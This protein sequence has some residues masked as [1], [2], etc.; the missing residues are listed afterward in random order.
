[1]TGTPLSSP[2]HHLPRRGLTRADILSRL[3]FLL[4]MLV[5]TTAL[6][7]S[8]WLAGQLGGLL[9]RWTWP[10]STPGDAPG[11]AFRLV[12]HLGSP[13]AAW[14][15]EARADLPPGWLFWLLTLLLFGGSQ[16]GLAVPLFTIARRIARRR[17]FASRGDLERRLTADAVLAKVDVIRPGL[18][19]VDS[20]DEA[21]RAKKEERRTD[22]LEVGR[23]LGTDVL[24]GTPLYLPNEYTMLV[25]AVPRFGNKTTRFVIPAVAD[26]RGAVL[27]TSTR[28]DV[29]EVTHDK[30]ARI[31]PTHIFEPQGE[32]PGV[33]RM[34]WSPIAGAEDPIVAMLRANGLAAGTGIGDQSV[35]NGK[36]FRDQAATILRGLL[37]AAALDGQATMID[38]L[39]W[40]QNP[41]NSRPEKILRHH[42]VDSWADRLARHRESTGRARD[43]IQSVV[44]AALDCVND[45][46]V[47]LACSPPRSEQFNVSDWLT[48]SGTIYLVGTRDAQ[49]LIAPLLSALT[50]DVFYQAKRLALIAPGGRLEPCLYYIG[51]EITNVA[52]P[53]SL[54][55]MWNE[56]GGAGIA[57][58]IFCQNTPQILNQWG[59]KGGRS[60]IDSAN[61]RL[62]LG[63]SSD[64]AALR[65]AQALAGKVNEISSGASWGG[66]R[67]S[68]NE[69]VRREDLI[70]L[71]DLRTLPEGRAIALI[72]NMSPIELAV[73]A[74][75]ERPDAAQLTADRDAF[76]RRLREAAR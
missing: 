60:I 53:A 14:P 6:T 72:G 69:N 30:R 17:G 56:G 48:K 20:D 28:L 5:L 71:A 2:G 70:D 29:A 57:E 19:I 3:A 22:P 43:N 10:D 75:W 64:V 76:R 39:A 65:D 27:T 62:I 55:S 50:E 36:W 33:P 37:H 16:A 63:G 49:A 21:A 25:A 18:T 7:W 42:K 4:L 34:R 47:L 73:P 8:V 32:I 44:A 15:A 61:A 11:I 58:S 26:A 41:G 59:E 40:S 9:T 24:T 46:R 66:G 68:V 13:A 38:V 67:A 23:F 12:A 1:M 54:P 35:E 45:P 51:D 74:W 31:G 52:P